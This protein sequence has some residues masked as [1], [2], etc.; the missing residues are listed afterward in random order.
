MMKYVKLFGDLGPVVAELSDAAAGR[1]LKAV[2][3]Y[4][5][6]AQ[7]PEISGPERIVFTILLKQFERDRD[8]YERKV[9]TGRQNALK[10]IARQKEANRGK[11][12]QEEEKEKEED[13]DKEKESVPAG[14][15][16]P[17]FTP[18]TPDEVAAY[19]QDKGYAVD[20]ERFCDFYASK[21]WRVGTSP[22]KDWKAAVRTWTKR[23]D[24][25]YGRSRSAG[26]VSGTAGPTNAFGLPDAIL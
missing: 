19:C 13:K 22:M 8:A 14:E 5:D 17:R 9:E 26:V 21:G 6:T 23:G 18:P 12:P 20:A 7:V 11:L 25:P 16:R 4:A 10:G 1:L 3:A 15:K 2:L 24:E